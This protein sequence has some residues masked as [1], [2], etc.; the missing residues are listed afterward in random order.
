MAKVD[1][2]FYYAFKQEFTIMFVAV[3]NQQLKQQ[4]NA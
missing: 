1:M 2:N 3:Q 4:N